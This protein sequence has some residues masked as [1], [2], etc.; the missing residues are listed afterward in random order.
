M[1]LNPAHIYIG[2]LIV[3]LIVDLIH[4]EGSVYNLHNRSAGSVNDINQTYSVSVGNKDSSGSWNLKV[5]DSAG[6]DTGY[7]DFWSITF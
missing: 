2:D 4:P 7:I 6:A 3:D 1:K 5:Q